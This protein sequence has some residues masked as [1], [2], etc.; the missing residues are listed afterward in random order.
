MLL[1]M[2]V[3]GVAAFDGVVG[4]D[5][6]TVCQVFAA[7][8]PPGRDSPYEVRVCGAPGT[9]VT[10][11][12]ADCFQLTAPF[13]LAEFAAADTILVPGVQDWTRPWPPEVLELLTDAAARGTR[14]ASICT[15]AFVLAAAGLLDGARATT[16]WNA[17]GHLAE[18]YP[19]VEVDPSVLFVD[20]GQVLT[21]A[22]VCAG[23]DLCLHLIRRDHGSALAARTARL[24]VMPAFREGGQAQFISY[25]LPSG[26]LRPTMDWMR[27]NLHRD[28]PLAEIARRASMSVRTLNRRFRDLT[29][30]TPLQWLVLARVHRAQELLETT[31]LP[32]EDVAHRSGFGSAATLRR[33]FADRVDTTPTAY[34]TAFRERSAR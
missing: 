22:G 19:Q 33:H 4:F 5:L 15:G 34:R 27:A 12:G 29:G 16:H 26:S 14:I 10:A 18:T 30:T 21:S 1:A 32:V 6:A 25:E 13:A 24:I 17:A 9:R 3:V 8:R 23:V 11:V 7:A 20:N 28:L 31:D 2:H